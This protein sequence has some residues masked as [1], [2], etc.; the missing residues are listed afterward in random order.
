MNHTWTLMEAERAFN[1]A[2][3]A[4]RRAGLMRRVRRYPAECGRLDVHDERRLPRL[5]GRA[6]VRE[7]PL[8][9]ITGTIEPARARDFDNEF[10][11][12]KLARDRWLRIW[13]AINHGR[14]LP[15]ISVVQV[16]DRYAIRDGHHRVSVARACGAAT[17]A[18]VV[19]A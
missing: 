14:S 12:S 3:A 11:P 1:Q 4:R 5:R 17:I 13:M 18:A 2:T 7:I 6:G 15:P 9:A 8:D 16:G 10:R 19:T